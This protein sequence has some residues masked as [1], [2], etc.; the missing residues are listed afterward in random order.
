M[1][2]IQE[3]I[4]NLPFGKKIWYYDSH[5]KMI[6]ETTLWGVELARTPENAGKDAG[7]LYICNFIVMARNF[8]KIVPHW[9]CFFTWK[10]VLEFIAEN[11]ELPLK[12]ENK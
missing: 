3:E 6:A 11:C 5:Y 2:K 7:K 12:G 8:T 9:H 1:T 4:A 10:E